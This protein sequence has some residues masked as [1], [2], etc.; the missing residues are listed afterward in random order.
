MHIGFVQKPPIVHV[1]YADVHRYPLCNM[2]HLIWV[3]TVCKRNRLG[4]SRI[5]SV[6]NHLAQEE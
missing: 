6:N 5:Q 1:D 3:F 2:L 4:V